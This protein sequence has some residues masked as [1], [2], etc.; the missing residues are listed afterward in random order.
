MIEFNLKHCNTSYVKR[1]LDEFAP[2]LA[3]SVTVTLYKEILP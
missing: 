3:E 1:L 2:A